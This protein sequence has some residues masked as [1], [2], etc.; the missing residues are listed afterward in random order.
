M[1]L[2]AAA[3]FSTLPATLQKELVNE[4]N[5]IVRNYRERRWE[6][7]ELDGG[8]FSEVAYTVLSGYLANGNYAT[9]ASKPARFDTACAQL[10]N[11]S[12]YPKS[13]RV[14]IPRVLVALYDIRNSRG[15]GHVGG[16]VDA[17]HMDSAFVLHAA[18]W[19]MAE[20]VRVFHGTDLAIATSIVEALTTR[21]SP[22]LWKV[23]EA[24]RILEPGM[25]L[26]EATLLLLHSVAN[27][28]RDE[29]LAGHLEQAR[30]ANY[31]R[32]LRTLHASKMIEFDEARGRAT[33]SP[34]GIRHVEDVV[35]PRHS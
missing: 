35:L 27:S 28:M 31:R 16:D 30:L 20:F 9:H 4:F 18:Q 1:T 21:E 3:A 13:A 25:R 24:I 8:R 19:V 7:A 29:E 2:D 12:G 23:G 32:V 10:G 26:G 22:I 6:A 34:R 15:V 11:F 14:S 5:K 17:N 33:I